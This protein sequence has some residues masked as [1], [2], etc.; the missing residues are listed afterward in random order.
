MQSIAKQVGRLLA[1]QKAQSAISFCF[2]ALLVIFLIFYLRRIE[3]ESIRGAS[4]ILWPLVVSA[5]LELL[6]RYWG[7]GV[8]LN[9]LRSIGASN[10]LSN[11]SGLTYAYSKA[12]LG[13]Y[14]PGTAPWILGKIYF[15]SKYGVSKQRLAVASLMEGALEAGAV[16]TLSI[17]MLLFSSGL[18]VITG[19]LRWILVIALAGCTIVMTPKVFNLLLSLAY[20]LLRRGSTYTGDYVPGRVILTAGALY[21]IG[22]IISG[23]SLFFVSRAFYPPLTLNSLLFIVGVGNL[24]AA[25]GMLAIFVPSGIGVRE[26]IFLVLLAVVMPKEAALLITVATRLWGVVM[27][28][29]FFAV[30]ALVYSYR[31][32]REKG[33]AF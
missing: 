27:D 30:N 9:I 17:I 16:L 14:I 26:G 29:L 31:Q 21:A 4:F 22:G 23:V 2:Y 18:D 25:L 8:W 28:L 1:N 7:I 33:Q 10:L 6:S 20:T 13:R 19:N 32:R 12:W 24:A 5:L 11:L 3:W 15:A